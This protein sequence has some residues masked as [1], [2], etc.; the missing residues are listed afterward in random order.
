[1]GK[2]EQKKGKSEQ[3]AAKYKPQPQLGEWMSGI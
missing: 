1:M 2:A 3:P